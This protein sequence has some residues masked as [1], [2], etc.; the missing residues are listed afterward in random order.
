MSSSRRRGRQSEFVERPLRLLYVGY[1]SR[2]RGLHTVVDAIGHLDEEDRRNVRLAVHYGGP[3]R[4]SDYS[5]EVKERVR[6][7]GLSDAVRFLGRVPHEEMASVYR[8]H[9]VLFPSM[10]GEG[11]P[12]TMM[13]A[14]ASGAAVITT[15][16]G[17]AIELADRARLPLF[18]KDHPV[19]LSRLISRLIRGPEALAEIADRGQRLVLSE[20]TLDGMVDRIERSL[21]SVAEREAE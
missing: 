2:D 21:R 9:H 1:L 19:A 4:D 8:R 7:R 13:E 15:G 12:L 6:E 3:V 10:R 14:M 17:G 20:F 11:L 18:P 5:R 16:S